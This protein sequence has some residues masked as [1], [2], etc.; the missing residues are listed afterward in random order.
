[1]GGAYIG[2]TSAAAGLSSQAIDVDDKTTIHFW[3][4]KSPDP[5]NPKP[6]LVLLHVFGPDTHWQWHPQVAFFARE[7]ALYIPNLL[8]LGNSTAKYAE[9]SEMFQAVSWVANNQST[10]PYMETTPTQ[11]HYLGHHIELKFM[12]EACPGSKTRSLGFAHVAKLRFLT[13]L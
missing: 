6:P 2:H 5:T 7:F 13:D 3:D 12:G 9:K 1:M 11:G 4:P 8:F 10:G